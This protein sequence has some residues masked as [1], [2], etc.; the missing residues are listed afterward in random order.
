[1]TGKLGA[2]A[3]AL[4]VAFGCSEPPTTSTA[5]SDDADVGTVAF[6]RGNDNGARIWLPDPGC[7]VIDGTGAFFWVDCRMQVTNPGTHG[8][9]NLVAQATGVPNPTGR[10]VHW[11]PD[12]PGWEF[13]VVFAEFFGVTEPPYPCAVF[14]N[15][16]DFV[17]TLNW[18]ATVTPSGNATFVC[19][20]GQNSAYEP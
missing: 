16:G 14:N 1:M 3:L 7:G 10:I 17:F 9:S 20:Y 5:A 6:G 8:N 18:H 13:E 15:D 19:H 4:L 11:G 12:N 2:A